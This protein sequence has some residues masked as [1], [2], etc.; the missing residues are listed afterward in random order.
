MVIGAACTMLMGPQAAQAGAACQ[1]GGSV[2]EVNACA[3]QDFQAAN[4]HHPDTMARWWARPGFRP[5]LLKTR[6]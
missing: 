1:P 2:V 4:Y 6:D 3:V 5:Y